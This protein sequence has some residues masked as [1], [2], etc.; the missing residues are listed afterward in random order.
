MKKHIS[1]LLL[2]GIF[3]IG[4]SLLLYPAFSDWW[5]SYHQ[6]RAILNY[7]SI[8]TQ[9]DEGADLALFQAADAYNEALSRIAFPLMHSDAAEGYEDTLNVDGN[10]IMGYI[11]I[12]KIQ[13]S[14]PIYHGTSESVL[15]IAVG[16]LE[17]TSLP[18]GEIGTHCGL[19]AHRGLPSARLFTDLDKLEP[20]DTFTVTV[21][22]RK[23]IYEID[24]ILVVEPQEVEALY[25]VPGQALCTLITCTPYGINSHRMLV[26]GRRIEEEAQPTELRVTADAVQTEPL[27]VALCLACPIL[28][29]ILFYP[30]RRKP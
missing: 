8:L 27:L 2:S 26:R 21:L 24:Q 11:E 16:H 1:T 6:S 5:N 22:H 23:I 18:T 15:Q 10:G 13:V 17:G 19:S 4:L 29:G 9:L 3:L 12:P 20:G 7:D 28:A 14:L 30:R 25:P